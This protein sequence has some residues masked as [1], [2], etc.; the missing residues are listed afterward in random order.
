M[1]PI[2]PLCGKVQDIV[3]PESSET[4]EYK[5]VPRI[6][7]SATHWPTDIQFHSYRIFKKIEDIWRWKTNFYWPDVISFSACARPK[8]VYTRV[9]V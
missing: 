6:V 9:Q 2:K 3:K 5:A 1:I 4:W 7:F 8:K